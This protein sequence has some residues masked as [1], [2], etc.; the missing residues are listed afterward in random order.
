MATKCCSVFGKHFDKA[1]E[2]KN[3]KRTIPF[4]LI[5]EEFST[6]NG[7]ALS[8]TIMYSHDRKSGMKISK[9]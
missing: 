8:F 6:D 2:C 1:L 5:L 9:H 3:V 7:K 4:L